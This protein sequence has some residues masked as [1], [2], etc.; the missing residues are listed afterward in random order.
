MQK[1]DLRLARM[2]ENMSADES[3]LPKGCTWD[4]RMAMRLAH[5]TVRHWVAVSDCASVMP[6]VLALANQWVVLLDYTLAQR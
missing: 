6:M 5:M 4:R 1:L 3:V 2:S